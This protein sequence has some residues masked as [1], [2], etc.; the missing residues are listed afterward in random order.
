MNEES[1]LPLR[2]G[3]KRKGVPDRNNNA[4][5]FAKK[6]K[7]GGEAGEIGSDEDEVDDDAEDDAGPNNQ[8]VGLE[9]GEVLEEQSFGEEDDDDDSP[10]SSSGSDSDDD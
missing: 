5:R 6:R 8:S 2:A 9:L 1:T 10:T 7:Q 3:N 4:S